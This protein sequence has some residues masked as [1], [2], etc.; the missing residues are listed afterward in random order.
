MPSSGGSTLTNIT[1]S[2]NT[3][4]IQIGQ[5][6]QFVA[7]AMDANGNPIPGINFTW[8]SSNQ[9]V[10][11]VDNTGL[12]T[13]GPSG[14]TTTI[15]ATSGSVSSNPSTL[16][17]A[18]STVSSVSVTPSPASIQ[19]GQT[20]QFVATAM[21]ANG[22]PIP[23]VTFMWASNIPS[24]A[25]I[26]STT[27]LANGLSGGTTIIT[28]SAGG[29]MSSGVQLQVTPGGRVYSTNFPMAENPISEGGN[30][31]NGGSVGI[32]WTDI[33][34]A[35]GLAFG[36]QPG[37]SN[38]PYNDS[39]AILSGTWGPNQT[40]TA[41]VYSVNQQ[42]GSIF[43]EIELLLRFQITADSARGYE[44]NFR[45]TQDGTQ[46]TQVVRWN[47]SL[48]DFTILDSRTGPGINNG[49]TVKAT[50]VGS[51]I[52]VY[53]NSMAIFSVNDS[54]WTDGNPGMGFFLQEATGLNSDYGF[55]SY[56]ASDGS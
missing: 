50:I 45:C 20:Q 17:V 18:L 53:I 37:N 46:Y 36:T 42:S 44:V 26:D 4:S 28:A 25:S 6:Q 29:V 1:L 8:T 11:G 2:P 49:D 15:T 19:V 31:I 12:A 7:T 51:L 47:G 24:V 55:T 10:A 32:D 38:P 14:G 27:G 34:T 13:A 21:D 43:E 22:N 35:R 48:G 56:T 9:T 30:W 39:I 33:Q 5:T 3:P 16:T 40:V 41:T 52:T 54:T 23:G